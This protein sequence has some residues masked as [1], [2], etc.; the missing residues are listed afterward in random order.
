MKKTL[1]INISGIIFH[2]EE[3]GYETL[4][5]YLDS[6]NR[7]FSSFEDSSE[8]L[9]DIE[10]RIAE[11]FLAKLNEGK[12]VITAEDVQHLIATMGNVSDFKAAEDQDSHRDDFASEPKYEQSSSSQPANKKLFRDQ[13]RKVLGGVCAGLAHYFGV[14]MVWPRLIFALLAFGYGGGILV[15]LVLW[16]VLPGNQ[17]IEEE[18]NIKKMYRKSE[19]KVL[20]GVAGGIAAYFGADIVLIRVIFAALSFFGGFGIIL[21]LIFWFSIPEAKTITE[22]MEM[23]GEPVTLSNIESNVKKSLNEKGE[24]ESALAKIVLFPF[25]ALAAIITFIG[26]ILG[27]VLVGIIEVVR[28]II[29]LAILLTGVGLIIF[30]LITLGILIGAISSSSL[31]E[32]W[33]LA[34]LEGTNFPIEALK[35]TVPTWSVIAAFFAAFVPAWFI[36]TLGSSIMSKRMLIRPVVAWSMFAVFFVSII[37]VSF[38]LPRIIFSFKEEGEFKTEKTFDVNGKT[39]VFKINETGLDDYH[40]T[41]LSIKG[42]DG[43][44]LKLTETFKAQGRSRKRA[45]EN[46]QTVSY[47]VVQ[48]DSVLTFDSNITFNKDAEFHAQRLELELLVP[49]NQKLVLDADTWRLLD[50]SG[51]WSY[52]ETDKP[53][54]WTVSPKGLVCSTCP[55]LP[56]E[57]QGLGDDDQ[58][59]LKDFEELDIKGVFNLSIHRGDK[60]S[61]SLSGSEK[62]RKK[63]KVDQAGNTLEIDYDSRNRTFWENDFNSDDP[64]RISITMPSLKKIKVKGAGQ[65]KIEGF[66][67]EQMDISFLGAMTCDAQVNARNL[68]LDLSGPMVF[69]LDGNGD[70]MEAEINKVAQLKA[71]GFNVR[72]AIIIAKELGRARVNPSEKLE[73]ETDVTGSVKYNGTPEVITKD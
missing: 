12:Q 44:I 52:S 29:G 19:G 48:A 31:P 72:H 17:N 8:I 51:R 7:Y 55:E 46:A 3:D 49:Y 2:I 18:T 10:S 61:V 63:Y 16:L 1:S 68:Q 58:F 47:N 6:I 37:I 70:F 57:Q 65:I 27:P 15:Y 33:G 54:T 59:G 24:E 62:E 5:K 26:K 56:K 43:K 13:K 9:A 67:E 71:S 53:Q 4:R 35:A 30:L 20:G 11:I 39:A 21:Y 32:S 64:F 60:Y 50:N 66:D 41:N 14:D 28:V 38:T 25:R 45:I 36:T 42:Y 34:H 23:Q 22:K 73:I 69:E 40:V